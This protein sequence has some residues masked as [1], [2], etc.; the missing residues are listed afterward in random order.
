MPLPRLTAVPFAAVLLLLW[1]GT[2]VSIAVPC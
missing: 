2:G 1:K